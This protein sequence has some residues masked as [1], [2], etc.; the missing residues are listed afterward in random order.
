MDYKLDEADRYELRNRIAW[1][2]YRLASSSM[3]LCSE[4]LGLSHYNMDYFE[5]IFQDL[6]DLKSIIKVIKSRTDRKKI[7]TCFD[8]T[9]AA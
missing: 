7:T 3:N 6:E 1:L 8:E 9:E 2:Q 5:K 4:G